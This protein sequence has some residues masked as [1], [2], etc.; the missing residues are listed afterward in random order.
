LPIA[1]HHEDHHFII[2]EIADDCRNGL[3]ARKT[4]CIKSSV[5]CNDFVAALKRMPDNGAVENT[6]LHNT[7]NHLLH[8]FLI[9]HL[10]LA[11]FEQAN[12][13]QRYLLYLFFG[14]LFWYGY[15]PLKCKKP[16]FRTYGCIDYFGY[17]YLIRIS[18]D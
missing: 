10:K 5:S 2:G 15:Y 16:Q 12:P 14:F 8:Q 6:R 4:G 3:P 9:H 17:L 18:C 13:W 1:V 11:I 7:A